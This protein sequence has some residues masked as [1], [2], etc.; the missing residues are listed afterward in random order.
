MNKGVVSVIIPIYNVEK[1]LKKCIESVITQSYSNLEI[2]LVNDGTKDASGI[3]CE[4]YYKSDN[5]IRYITKLNGGLSSARNA[6]LEIATGEFILFVDSDDFIEKD[7][8]K[9]CVFNIIKNESDL[10]IFNFSRI[11][12]SSYV[13]KGEELFL[14]NKTYDLHDIG[15]DNYVIKNF[16]NYDHGVEAWNRF[17]RRSL[18]VN[19]GIYFVDNNKI[20]A[21]D[22]LFNLCYLVHVD[23][24]TTLKKSYYNYLI[25]NSSIMTLPKEKLISKFF[26]LFKYLQ[27]HLEGKNNQKLNKVLP[28]TFFVWMFYAF[29]TSL[30]NGFE[31]KQVL[32]EL[33]IISSDNLFKVWT[34]DLLR[35]ET[36]IRFL[37]FNPNKVLYISFLYIMALC[38]LIRMDILV[39]AMISFVFKS[40]KI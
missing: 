32:E 12:E 35:H 9:D 40:K 16:L 22:L 15:I 19:N 21:E 39:I 29:K 24:L 11:F 38:F 3:I 30:Q 7:L 37:F 18:I 2:I 5:R 28:L 34:K 14:S 33:K 13:S 8:V 23:K 26:N 6:G 4:S 36:I 31:K 27:T 25:R 20:F 1:Y 17:Y 10:V